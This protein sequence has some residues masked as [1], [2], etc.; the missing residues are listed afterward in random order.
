MRLFLLSIFFVF[1]L[2]SCKETDKE[3]AQQIDPD[4]IWL[5]YRIWGDEESG[6][7]TVKAQFRAFGSSG[8]ALKLQSPASIRL[9]G[10]ELSFDSTRMNGG[11]YELIVPAH[12]FEGKHILSF[13]DINKKEFRQ[14][15]EFQPLTLL[16]EIP[17]EINSDS[18]EILLEGVAARD[19]LRIII[20]DTTAFSEGIDRVDTAR[21]GRIVIDSQ[22]LADLT[23]GPIFIELA[24]ERERR[25][26]NGSGRG[27]RIWMAFSLK[28][29]A[30][31]IR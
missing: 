20:M 13:T 8:N 15:F 16:E 29:H 10:K 19:R 22:Q 1:L 27:G 28:R 6:F 23:P 31:L 11:Y 30:V 25:V 24:R 4:D 12:E 21:D 17:E 2:F 26:K 9:D 18:L 5:D 3:N 7:V 14:E